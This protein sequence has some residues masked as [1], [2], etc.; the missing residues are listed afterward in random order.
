MYSVPSNASVRLD[1]V[2]RGVTPLT[3]YNISVGSHWI[4]LI[5]TG[6]ETWTSNVSIYA[7]QYTVISQ[8][9]T[10]NSTGNSTG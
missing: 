5:K 6:Y 1:Y 9:L 7:G 10:T 8:T 4:T 2:T 3:L